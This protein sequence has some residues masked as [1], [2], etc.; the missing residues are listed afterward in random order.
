MTPRAI[1]SKKFT[2][3]SMNPS[4]HN[5][6]SIRRAMLAKRAAIGQARRD[7]AHR[8]GFEAVI[9][10]L[11]QEGDVLSYASFQSEFDTTKINEFLASQGRLVLPK[12]EGHELTLYRVENFPNSLIKNSLGILEPDPIHSTKISPT[13]ITCAL[14]P[15]IAFNEDGH[16][17]GYGKGYYDRLLPKLN[18]ALKI[19]I[20]YKEQL[21]NNPSIFDNN[22]DTKTDNLIFG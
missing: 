3:T 4:S 9:R 13:A 19:G 6:E 5:K 14:I 7:I 10:A 17:I 16:R 21:I 1:S 18:N 15:A 20:G 11:P 8:T 12:I 22:S 2:I